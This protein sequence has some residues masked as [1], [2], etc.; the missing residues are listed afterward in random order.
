MIDKIYILRLSII[1]IVFFLILLLKMRSCSKRKQ[2]LLFFLVALSLSTIAF[3]TEPLPTWDL[4]RHFALMDTIRNSG[5]SL[6]DFLFYNTRNL[7]SYQT[8]FS[9]NFLRFVICKLTLNN[10][11]LPCICVFI[12]YLIVGYIM[13][14]WYV[15]NSP[16]ERIGILSLLVCFAFLPLIHAISGMRNALA[17]SLTGLAIYLY[18]YKKKPL[19]IPIVLFFISATVHPVVL[20]TIPFVCLA[21]YHIGKKGI[22]FVF[23]LSLSLNKIAQFFSNSSIP[24]ISTLAKKYIAYSSES[25][26]WGGNY[27]LWGT[28]ILIASF[29]FL[30][31]FLEKFFRKLLWSDEQQT[32]YNFLIYYM[33]FILGNIGNY[34]LVLR[35]AYLLGL[36]APILVSLLENRVVWTHIHGQGI[37]LCGKILCSV[38]CLLMIYIYIWPV[39]ETL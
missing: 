7:G 21:R 4:A 6:M 17:C 12:D 36:F 11:W 18:L 39:L 22:G 3:Y 1:Y 38:L 24:Y 30:Y 10:H 31:L 9:F 2:K 26:Y 5:I 19:L 33:C 29:V 25:Q 37:Q 20:F 8:L 28:L 15:S 27:P 14:D 13:L 32:L 35:P 34:D 16:T 23:L